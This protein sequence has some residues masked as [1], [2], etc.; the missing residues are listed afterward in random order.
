MR[1]L[2]GWDRKDLRS[3]DS[4]SQKDQQHLYGLAYVCPG[5]INEI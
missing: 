4:F 3:L 2:T 1:T 5:G